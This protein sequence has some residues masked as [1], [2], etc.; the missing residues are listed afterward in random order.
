MKIILEN[1]LDLTKIKHWVFDLDNTLYPASSN[2]FNKIDVRMKKFIIKKLKIEPDE[3]YKIQ[4]KYYI[5]YGTTLSGLMKNHNVMPKEFLDYVHKIDTSSLKV[6][7]RLKKALKKL[8]GELYIYTN[9][10]KSHAINVMK[11]LEINKYINKIFDIENANY[12][13]KPS[14]ESL[15]IFI[16]KYNINPKEAVFFEDISKNLINAKKIGFQTVLI[17][18]ASHPDK[19]IQVIKEENINNKFIDH[20]SYDLPAT[21]G[22]IYLDI[23]H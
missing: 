8:P 20:I 11:R 23:N 16:K 21:L 7:I 22:E 19:N 5:E 14:K 2:L 18:N 3:A 10:S 15:D 1:N 9:A 4:K 6:D 17:K 13:P 12:T